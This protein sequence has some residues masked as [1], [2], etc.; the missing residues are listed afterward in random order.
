MCRKHFIDNVS[1]DS[2]GKFVVK[3]SSRD[4]VDKL[5]ESYNIALKRFLSLERRLSKNLELYCQYKGFMEE[6]EHLG[7]MEKVDE[8][9]DISVKT[10][11]MPHSYVLN[12][13][14]RTTKL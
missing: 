11:Y 13:H 10:Y 5:G 7:H 1:V 3:L 8:D 12:E 4:N 9:K 6:Y 2:M 14:S